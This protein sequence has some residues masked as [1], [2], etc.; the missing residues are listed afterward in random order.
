MLA[1]RP[2]L[3]LRSLH[4]RDGWPNGTHL[5]TLGQTFQT[6]LRSGGGARSDRCRPALVRGVGGSRSLPDGRPEAHCGQPRRALGRGDSGLLLRPFTPVGE[7]QQGGA[8][9][10]GI[11]GD[12][13]YPLPIRHR[14][15]VRPHTR[16]RCEPGFLSSV[17]RPGWSTCGAPAAR[18]ALE[19]SS[20][21]GCREGR[22]AGA[23]AYRVSSPRRTGSKCPCAGTAS[24]RDV[25][26]RTSGPASGT[27]GADL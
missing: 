20:P 9:Y 10:V 11:C 4:S 21:A 17:S 1:R 5:P 22:G 26:A 14:L 16:L 23:S 6:A 25:A 19:R 18:R 15:R 24:A 13:A 2:R 3:L 12:A 7:E 27:D 8:V